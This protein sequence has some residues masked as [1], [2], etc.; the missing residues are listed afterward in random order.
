MG[1]MDMP[2][3]VG[4]LQ[5]NGWILN[6]YTCLTVYAGACPARRWHF[7]VQLAYRGWPHVP[8]R[9]RGLWVLRLVH[10]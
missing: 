3:I 10:V 5:A 8:H 4:G 9:A 2:Q 6:S 7:R 1:Y